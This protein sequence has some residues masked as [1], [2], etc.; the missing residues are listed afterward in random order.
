MAV[1]IKA[2]VK[3][4]PA[5]ITAVSGIAGLAE[6]SAVFV[7]G[8]VSLEIATFAAVPCLVIIVFI[9]QRLKRYR[10]KGP[11]AWAVVPVLAIA[12]TVG[13]LGGLGIA[14]ATVALR[15]AAGSTSPSGSGS[16]SASTSDEAGCGQAVGGTEAGRILL[17]IDGA[18]D[19][20]VGNILTSYG[21]IQGLPSA[22]HLLLFLRADD[23]AAYLA[24]DTVD[25]MVCGSAWS[26]NIYVNGGVPIHAAFTL[27]LVDLGP[28]SWDYV[29]SPAQLSLLQN[30]FPSATPGPDARILSETH[31]VS[32]PTG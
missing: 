32:Y 26:L 11:S 17:P 19:I 25:S 20:P 28:G 9:W 4:M 27:Y 13:T 7:H 21:T 12:L 22:H 10:G 2:A 8:Q 14:S 16:G 15:H 5:A 6:L 24:G 1:D 30:G 23:T 29:N 18:T 3:A 31:F